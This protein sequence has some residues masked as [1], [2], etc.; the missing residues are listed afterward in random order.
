MNDKEFLEHYGVKGMRW[1]VRKASTHASEDSA[2]ASSYKTRAKTE[3]IHTLTNKE[4]QDYITRANLEQQFSRLSTGSASTSKGKKFTSDVL[5]Q[6]AREQVKNILM[7]Q[8][9]MLIAKQFPKLLNK[10]K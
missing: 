10:G 9:T 5:Q 7:S 6:V 8:T 4:L 2:R 1:G 3:G